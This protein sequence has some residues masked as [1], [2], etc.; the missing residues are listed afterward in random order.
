MF[1]YTVNSKKKIVHTAECRFV[2]KNESKHW[3][4]FDTLEQAYV[5]GYRRCKCCSPM[6][7]RFRKERKQIKDFHR[8]HGVRSY[9]WNDQIEVVTL[10]SQWKIIEGEGEILLYHQNTDPNRKAS[11][12]SA[13]KGFHLQRVFKTSIAAY[14]QEI[15]AHDDYRLEYPLKLKEVK[16]KPRKGTKA[17]R[18]KAAIEKRCEKKR[19]VKRVLN[20]IDELSGREPYFSSKA[21]GKGLQETYA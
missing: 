5:K 6:G 16:K 9:L 10:Y 19:S 20:L 21:P 11:I 12:Q 1:Y 18:H 8:E 7:K 15:V 4:T 3:K 14:L 17:Y 2:N 13:I